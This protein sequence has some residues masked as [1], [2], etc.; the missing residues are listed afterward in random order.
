MS[1]LWDICGGKRNKNL[2]WGD[3]LHQNVKPA[4]G[5][6]PGSLAWEYILKNT[7]CNLKNGLY[8]QISDFWFLISDL[9]E[10]DDL[11]TELPPPSLVSDMGCKSFTY[12]WHKK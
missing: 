2:H 4:L 1:D 9:W 10:A 5:F 3:P 7:Q 6:E 11:P 8:E 12:E